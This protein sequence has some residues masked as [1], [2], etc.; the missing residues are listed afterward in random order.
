MAPFNQQPSI[1]LRKSK[2]QRQKEQ[3]Q[4]LD[5]AIRKGLTGRALRRAV[6]IG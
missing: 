2:Q 4:R 3:Q 6:L 5:R 1:T